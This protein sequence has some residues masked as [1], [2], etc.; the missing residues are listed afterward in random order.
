MRL[1]FVLVVL[2]LS[3]SACSDPGSDST[4]ATGGVGGAAGTAGVGGAATAGGS[5]G[6]GGTTVTCNDLVLDAPV[7]SSGSTLDAPPEALG[8]QVLDGTY[9][10]TAMLAYQTDTIPVVALGR[11]KVVIEGSSWQ[12]VGGDPEPDSVN[13][14]VRATRTVSAAGTSLTI[15]PTCPEAGQPETLDFTA[16][17]ESLTLCTLDHGIYFCTVLARQ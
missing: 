6:T 1:A 9:F 5:T 2:V 10:V 14:D 8:G 3:A 12:E 7:Y 4:D 15:T 17:A 11:Q 13:P 16:S